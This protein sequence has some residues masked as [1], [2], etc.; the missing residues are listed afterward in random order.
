[1]AIRLSGMIS[2]LDTDAIVKELMS[3]Q[4]LKKTNIEQKKEKLSWKKEKWEELNTKIYA[5]YTEKLSSLKL[6]GSY[7]T[8]KASSSNS[9]KA[10][11]SAT[12]AANGSYSLKI[13][14]L[15]SAQFVTGAD[16]S[17]KKLTKSSKLTDA[18]M[19]LQ[20]LT[21]RMGENLEKEVDIDIEDNM[22]FTDLAGKLGEAGL[23]A[24]FDEAS[25]RF[26]I[27]AKDTGEK[28]KFTLTS[29]QSGDA[30]LAAIGL[31]EI[32]ETLATSGQDAPES[33]TVA[34]VAAK[35][36]KYILNGATIT[37]S[38]NTVNA[39]GLTIELKGTTSE[40]EVI[41]LTV[42]NDT[43]AVYD[44]IKEFVKSYNELVEDMYGKYTA[45][46]AKDYHMLTDEEKEAMTDDQVELWE[47]KIKD[48]LLRSDTTLN[49]LMT[50]FRTA[51]QA[52]V[53]V[54]GETFG[55]ASF[56]IE[57]GNYLEHGILHINGNADD[58]EYADKTDKLKEALSKDPDKTGQALSKIFSEFY[59]TLSDK[60]S[61]NS[62]SSA[63]TLYNDKQIQ[64]QMDDYEKQISNWEDR[65]EDL[66]ERY[67]KQF[68]GMEKAMANLQSQQNQLA[69]L[70]GMS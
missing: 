38:T 42:S 11:A 14:S 59:K 60:M 50:T 19:S 55:L 46:S 48:S 39:N 26:Y 5:L 61:A 21:V 52:T 16:I 45:S 9:E 6:E 58:G 47:N 1:M 35:N 34:V 67:Y 54:D 37:S 13:E 56:G 69:G 62:I 29:N 17:A 44:K 3:A 18:G 33:G 10:T 53:T 12:N 22:T 36:A 24:S 2:N 65:L 64:S 66:E 70:L 15:A 43:D 30:G 57:T 68:A 63:L 40:G 20:T 4:S 51:M 31:T 27:S 28:G 25:G 32:D 8:K 7:L 49:S 41:N 23:N